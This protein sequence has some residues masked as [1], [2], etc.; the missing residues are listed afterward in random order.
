[1]KD[2]PSQQSAE[3]EID[4]VAFA[5]PKTPD[6]GYTVKASYLKPP[7]NLDALIQVFR[8]GQE[9]RS[10][11][12]PAYKIWNI[13]AHFSDIVDSEIAKN[14]DGYK[15][16]AWNEITGATFIAPHNES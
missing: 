8:D 13:A 9:V 15:A 3:H 6:R 2:Q 1:M 7:H 11:L 5:G 10:F 4:S 14:A 16:A 12:F